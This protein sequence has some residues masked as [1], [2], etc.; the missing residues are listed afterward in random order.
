[1]LF[2]ALS[3][4]FYNKQIRP[5]YSAWIVLR[6]MKVDYKVKQ[7]QKIYEGIWF[8]YLL[9]TKSLL[10]GLDLRMKTEGHGW[11]WSFM[12]GKDSLTNLIGQNLIM[13]GV[14]T[15]SK[16]Q[17]VHVCCPAVTL[18]IVLLFFEVVRFNL[19]HLSMHLVSYLVL[20]CSSEQCKMCC[21]TIYAFKTIMQYNYKNYLI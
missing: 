17:H 13:W 15:D 18:A 19:L 6:P 8:N 9:R 10:H 2:P 16:E 1:M 4:S 21:D 5:I 3:V 20:W 14:L 11:Y 12:N 7:S